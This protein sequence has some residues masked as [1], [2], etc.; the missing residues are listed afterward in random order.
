MERIV[1]VIELRLGATT[2]PF[3]PHLRGPL[4]AASPRHRSLHKPS[5]VD[6]PL[7]SGLGQDRKSYLIRPFRALMT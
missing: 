3:F 5:A 4:S 1:L 6:F 2:T 7:L